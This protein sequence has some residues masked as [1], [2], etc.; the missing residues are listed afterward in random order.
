MNTQDKKRQRNQPSTTEKVSNMNTQ[1]E[2]PNPFDPSQFAVNSTILGG[3]GVIKEMVTCPVRKPTKQ[4]F[5]RVHPDQEY[6][7]QSYFLELKDEQESYLVMPSVAMELPGEVRVVSL[8][9]AINRNGSVFM[10]P[11]P[12][13]GIDGRDNHWWSSARAAALRSEKAWTRIISNKSG[14]LYDVYV[15]TVNLPEPEW[16]EKTLGE[17]IKI[18]FG[19]RY[20][21]RDTNHPVIQRLMGLV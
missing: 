18:A 21:I 7:L 9:L 16:P 20:I 11:L 6:Q 10:W 3:G 19:E 14:G 5:F 2:N 1:L 13:P 4:E 12:I 8:R 17:I 15:A